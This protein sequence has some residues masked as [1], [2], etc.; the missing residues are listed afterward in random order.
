MNTI[1]VIGNVGRDPE[2]KITKNNLAV[3]KFSLADTKGKKGENQKTSWY[4]IVVF[5][6]LAENVASEIHK[7]ERLLV[8]G[9]LQVE[10]YTKTD[11]T[12]GKRVE[13]IADYIGD[14]LSNFEKQQSGEQLLKQAFN[15]EDEDEF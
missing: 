12:K 3:C 4:D 2:L 11:G 7:G 5:G 1:T 6:A 10:D 15:I 8:L 14:A 9:T 13:I